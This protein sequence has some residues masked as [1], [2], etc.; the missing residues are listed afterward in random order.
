MYSMNKLKQGNIR[1]IFQ[2]CCPKVQ[3]QEISNVI[4]VSQMNI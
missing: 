1:Y 4:P 2:G 3:A